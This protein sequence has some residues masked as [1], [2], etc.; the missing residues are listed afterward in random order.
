MS[1]F[2]ISGTHSTGK[3]T[4][5][6]LIR[7]QYHNVNIVDEVPRAICQEL[8]DAKFFHRDHNSFAKQTLLISKQIVSEVTTQQMDKITI[9]DRCVADHWAYTQV[10]F[11]EEC[12]NVTGNQWR[13]LVFNWM[14]TYDLIFVCSLE[15]ALEYGHVRERDMAF[16]ETIDRQIRDILRETKSQVVNLSGSTKER[17]A[18]FAVATSSHSVQIDWEHVSHKREKGDD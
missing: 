4:L 12:S 13:Q 2:A 7:E 18:T 17:L 8:N 6:D 11:T 3:S 1:K 16:R 14:Q 15:A 10:Q 5:V 9:T